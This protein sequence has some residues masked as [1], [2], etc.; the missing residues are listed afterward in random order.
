MVDSNDGDALASGDDSGHRTL[1]SL[2]RSLDPA[3]PLPSDTISCS[4][5]ADDQV[6]L[7]PSAC[8]LQEALD[9]SN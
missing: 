3:N 5:H 9:G 6:I 2:M 4:P 1:M 8:G 7:A